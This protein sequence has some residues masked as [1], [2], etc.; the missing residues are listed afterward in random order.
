M[1][2]VDRDLLDATAVLQDAFGELGRPEPDSPPCHWCGEPVGDKACPLYLEKL[3][4]DES[5]AA[6]ITLKNPRWFCDPDCLLSFVQMRL[7]GTF[8]PKPGL[9]PKT[10]PTQ[11][12]A[13]R[14]PR[15]KR[16]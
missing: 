8:R 15:G 6:G 4:E 10:R 16:R 2:A 1:T 5:L 14:K 9:T 13:T 7:G 3:C 12:V 11:E